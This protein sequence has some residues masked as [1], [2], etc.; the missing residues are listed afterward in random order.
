MFAFTFMGGN[1][2]NLIII[3]N[4]LPMFALNGKNYHHIGSLLPPSEK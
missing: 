3:G 4:A 1:I 2:C